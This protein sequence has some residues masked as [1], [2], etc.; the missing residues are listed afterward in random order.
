MA[1]GLS[2]S[3]LVGNRWNGRG[4]RSDNV[5]VEWSLNYLALTDFG[6][7]LVKCSGKTKNTNVVLTVRSSW[8]RGDQP[9]V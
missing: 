9:S 1:T 5:I 2:L 8:D 6:V 7:T 4:D 3:P